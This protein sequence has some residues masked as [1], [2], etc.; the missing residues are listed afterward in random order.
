MDIKKLLE[1][2]FKILQVDGEDI[3]KDV[4]SN[5][6][7]INDELAK[8]VQDAIKAKDSELLSMES[9]KNNPE[10]KEHFR[11]E[12]FPSIKGEV[13]GNIDS[14]LSQAAKTLFGEEKAK[15]LEQHEK[16]QDKVKEFIT[17]SE[18]ILKSKFSED[19][20]KKLLENQQKQIEELQK[21]NKEEVEK[22]RGEYE[23]KESEFHSALV[24]NQ[25]AQMAK[26]QKWREPFQK[27]SVQKA[28]IDQLYGEVMRDAVPK[29]NDQGEIEL[30]N[31][32]G[33]IKFDGNKK[34][35]VKDKLESL[36]R[37]N[38][39]IDMSPTK[40]GDR[41]QTHFRSEPVKDQKGLPDVQRAVKDSRDS[42]EYLNQ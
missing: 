6:S 37:E 12:M 28:L 14:S 11:K 9:A 42:F 16:T 34:V 25:F 29:L 8:K 36:M 27:E 32:D 20:K 3:L 15:A 17:L 7:A 40:D 30:Y 33:T 4:K 24:K 13:L 18:T 35:A 5:E 1:F 31:S 41:K 10:L 22:L 21:A 26:S 2:I 19:E 23:Q 39:F 38:E